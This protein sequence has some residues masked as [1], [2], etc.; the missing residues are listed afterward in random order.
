MGKTL[1]ER[2]TALCRLKKK[3]S[4]RPRVRMSMQDAGKPPTDAAESRPLPSAHFISVTDYPTKQ[5]FIHGNASEVCRVTG[6]AAE[7]PSWVNR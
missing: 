3:S 5:F 4:G 6:F 1:K 2:E 7:V